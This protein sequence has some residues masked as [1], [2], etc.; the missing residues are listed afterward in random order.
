MKDVNDISRVHERLQTNL[1]TGGV[2]P[3]GLIHG[4]VTT[5]NNIGGG[6]D[7]VAKAVDDLTVEFRLTRCE[8]IEADD[9]CWSYYLISLIMMILGRAVP[10]LV[11]AGSPLTN[12]NILPA[13]LLH[14]ESSSLGAKQK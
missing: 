11:N 3:A 14:P 4:A 2:G 5:A 6:V 9:F 1:S 10:V 8:D 7:G 13:L 12:T